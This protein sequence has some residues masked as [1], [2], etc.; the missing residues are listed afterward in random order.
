MDIGNWI[1]IGAIITIGGAATYYYGKLLNDLK[2]QQENRPYT[3]VSGFWFLVGYILI[4]FAFVYNKKVH[5]FLYGVFS[6]LL[7]S[8]IYIITLFFILSVVGFMMSAEYNRRIEIF[9]KM[10]FMNPVN[11]IETQNRESLRMIKWAIIWWILVFLYI[12]PIAVLIFSFDM[13]N[14]PMLILYIAL[15]ILYTSLVALLRGAY[16]TY[17][18]PIKVVLN[19][20]EEIEGML[21]EFK[22]PI[23]VWKIKDLENG[24]QLRIKYNIPR[25]SVNYTVNKV[26]VKP[27]KHN[28][29][30]RLKKIREKEASEDAGMGRMREAGD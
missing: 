2:P 7:Y 20:G 22:D 25:N 4:P 1:N 27:P 21:W 18:F 10:D 5:D 19:N 11:H 26:V 3:Y 16:S 24:K 30:F 13:A 29:Q 14:V 12:T 17:Y 8:I 6:S 9:L 23:V 28:I 15:A